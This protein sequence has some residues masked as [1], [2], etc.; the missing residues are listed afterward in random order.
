MNNMEKYNT[1]K[2]KVIELAAGQ[3]LLSESLQGN[4][5]MKEHDYGDGGFT[6]E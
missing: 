6:Q 2:S 4:K 3:Q 5:P 1:P